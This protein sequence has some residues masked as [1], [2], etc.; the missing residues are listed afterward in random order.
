MITVAEQTVVCPVGCGRA[1]GDHRDPVDEEHHNREDRQTQPAIRHDTVDLI[2]YGQF[3]C[4][5]LLIAGLDDV[6]DP[7]IPFVGDDAFRVV[8]QFLLGGGDVLLDVRFGLFGNVQAFHNLAVALKDLDRVPALLL[9]RHVVH[10]RF[11]DVRKRMLD[12]AGEGM[13]RNGFGSLR[14][15]DRFL[16]GFGDAGAL[17]RGDLNDLAAD[18]LREFRGVDPVAALFHDVHHVDRHDH[19]NAELDELR[20]EVEVALE[21]RAVHDVQNRVRTFVDQVIP[22]DDFLQRVGGKR[23]D[24]GKVRDDHVVV[25]LQFAFLLFHG[26]ARPVAYELVRAGQRVEQGRFAAVRVA[27]EGNANTHNTSSNVSLS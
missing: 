17:Q 27:R 15:L 21:V 8:I 10:N 18:L 23:I 1:D 7:D 26:D 4:A 12:R 14:R 2:G 11:L 25:I 3:A 5:L 6:A 19:R 13:L 16:G 9:L 22:G 24:T 20:G